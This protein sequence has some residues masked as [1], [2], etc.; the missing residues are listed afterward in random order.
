MFDEKLAGMQSFGLKRR[1]IGRDE[2]PMSDFPS[3]HADET[4]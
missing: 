3:E 4:E 2:P 1:T